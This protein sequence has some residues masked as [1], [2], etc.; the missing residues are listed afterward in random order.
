M[1]CA[2]LWLLHAGSA[3]P[4]CLSLRVPLNSGNNLSL[5]TCPGSLLS[6][7]SPHCLGT[8]CTGVAVSP[9]VPCAN[10]QKNTISVS[11]T[12]RWA[13]LC[14]LVCQALQQPRRRGAAWGLCT[15]P[16]ALP[17][18]EDAWKVPDIIQANPPHDR[19]SGPFVTWHRE[20]CP[21]D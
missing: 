4:G 18:S 19:V 15:T 12:Q 6:G 1:L 10:I 16:C 5:R 21:Q 20:P 9:H 17:H 7:H 8:V 13:P 3:A 2:G 14:W 11:V